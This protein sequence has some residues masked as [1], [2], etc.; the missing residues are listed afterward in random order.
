MAPDGQ[1][2]EDDAEAL[3]YTEDLLL[4]STNRLYNDPMYCRM[5]YN[6]WLKKLNMLLQILPFKGPHPK[7]QLLLIPKLYN[8]HCLLPSRG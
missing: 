2:F 4:N 6:H 7:L 3:Q 1:M 8:I 5:M